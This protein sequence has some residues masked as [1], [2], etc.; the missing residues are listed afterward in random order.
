MVASTDFYEI[1]TSSRLFKASPAVLFLFSS[2]C[3]TISGSLTVCLDS[4]AANRTCCTKLELNGF[5]ISSVYKLPR[6]D[7]G[8]WKESQSW[9]WI[10]TRKTY[11]LFFYGDAIV[12][13]WTKISSEKLDNELHVKVKTCVKQKHACVF[14]FPNQS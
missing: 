1:F 8:D 3:I 5:Q 14:D 12:I 13:T 9:C 2:S 6:S 7:R 11:E 4:T 10:E